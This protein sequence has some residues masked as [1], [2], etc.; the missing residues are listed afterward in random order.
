MH[1]NFL[2]RLQVFYDVYT[3]MI[4]VFWFFLISVFLL[5]HLDQGGV[6]ERIKPGLVAHACNPSTGEGEA[7]QL[8]LVHTQLG[9][10]SEF[11][12]LDY[13]TIPRLKS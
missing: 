7:G 11:H 3:W 10:Q 13:R 1:D 4:S 6:E 9:L 12:R 8:P 5:Y 2:P